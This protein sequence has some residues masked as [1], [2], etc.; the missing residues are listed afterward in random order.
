MSELTERLREGRERAAGEFVTWHCRD[1]HE[2]NAHPKATGVWCPEAGHK[3]TNAMRRKDLYP[4]WARKREEP[5][6]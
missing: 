2:L 6:E 1:G 5:E 4:N 3:G